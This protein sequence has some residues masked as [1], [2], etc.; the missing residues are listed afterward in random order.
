ML[1]VSGHLT[2]YSNGD[3]RMHSFLHAYACA[4]AS[5]GGYVDFSI[6]LPGSADVPGFWAAAWLM[7][8]LGRAGY[9]KSLEGV[10]PFSYDAC[11]D[12]AE[13]PPWTNKTAQRISN[14]N[15]QPKKGVGA[16]AET[17]AEAGAEAGAGAGAGCAALQP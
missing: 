11:D 8:N 14:C 3:A 5:A 15:T 10:W 13:I 12:G 1:N 7:G 4:S 6:K 17:G 16:G 2:A 9:Y